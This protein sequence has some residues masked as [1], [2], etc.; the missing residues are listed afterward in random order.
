MFSLDEDFGGLFVRKR[1]ISFE[2]GKGFL[3]DDPNKILE[4]KGKYRRH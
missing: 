1:H 4:G 3:M 2:F